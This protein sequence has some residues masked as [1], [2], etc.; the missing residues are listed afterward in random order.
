M[1]VLTV[2]IGIFYAVT[3]TNLLVR[4]S[5]D[6]YT[7]SSPSGEAIELRFTD[8]KIG[9]NVVIIDKN[10]ENTFNILQA[11]QEIVMFKKQSETFTLERAD[12]RLLRE[13]DALVSILYCNVSSFRM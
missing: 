4:Y 7:C 6:I 2:A 8:I 13:L 5:Y 3:S 10:G 1:V 11:S 12:K 9:E